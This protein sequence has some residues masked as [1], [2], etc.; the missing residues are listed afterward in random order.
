MSAVA[1]DTVLGRADLVAPGAMSDVVAGV[2]GPAAGRVVAIEVLEHKPGRRALLRYETEAAGT[3]YGKVFADHAHAGR[4]HDLMDAVAAAL[5]PSGAATPRPLGVVADM[6][7][8][9]YEP[10][11]GPSLDTLAGTDDMVGALAAAAGWLTTLHTSSAALDRVLDNRH[12]AD[13]A[14]TWSSAVAAAFPDLADAASRLAAAVAARVPA[15]AGPAVPIHKDFHYQHVILGDRLGVV[16]LDEARMGDRLFDVGHFAANLALLA[17]RTGAAD[18]D[19]WCRAFL[20]SCDVAPA[21]DGHLR[22][23]GAYTCV[24]IAKQ[25][26]TGQGPRP[27]PDGAEARAQAEWALHHGLELIQG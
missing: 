3:V 7:L 19:R 12:E 11:R 10:L 26:A 22:W 24:K 16:D 2:L 13:N 21:E 5:A 1:D 14:T 27:R 17:H 4:A 20:E 6:G 8:V 15:P 18:A 9:L 23:Y 25:L